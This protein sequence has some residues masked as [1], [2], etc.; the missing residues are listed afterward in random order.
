MIRRPPRSPRT[1]ARV[2]YTT[3][4]RSDPLVVDGAGLG[5]PQA[6]ARTGDVLTTDLHRTEHVL[7][8]PLL[9]ARHD[10][11]G[12]VADQGGTTGEVGGVRAV[13]AVELLQ[14]GRAHV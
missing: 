14:I 5:H 2:P 1:D 6:R 10:A 9:V 11:C 8:G 12:E 3:L 13:V 7:D 4:F